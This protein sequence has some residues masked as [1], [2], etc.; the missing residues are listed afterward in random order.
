MANNN[1]KNFQAVRVKK[2]H[3]ICNGVFYHNL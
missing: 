3:A 2:Y 1:N